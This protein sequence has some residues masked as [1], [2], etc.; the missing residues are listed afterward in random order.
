MVINLIKSIFPS[1]NQR[2]IEK[3]YTFVEQINTY[4]EEY[5]NLSEEQLKNKT[6]EFRE[7]I[8]NGETV[9]DI[10]PEAFARSVSPGPQTS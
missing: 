9:D 2:E 8:A 7:R 1:K 5:Q 4:Y 6:V 10:L 3:L